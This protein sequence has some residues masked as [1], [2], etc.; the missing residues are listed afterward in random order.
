MRRVTAAALLLAATL[1]PAF[2]GTIE[3]TQA[4]FGGFCVESR[5]PFIAI[6]RDPAKRHYRLREYRS[7]ATVYIQA[8]EAPAFP[9]C[10]PLICR[11]ETGDG[12][13]RAVNIRTDRLLARLIGPFPPCEGDTPQMVHLYVYIPTIDL[14]EFA[15]T[16]KCP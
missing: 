10:S 11:T 16:R 9:L 5:L 7:E 13:T 14:N 12:E 1:A 2:G 8:G 15:V 4:C 6:F 3:L